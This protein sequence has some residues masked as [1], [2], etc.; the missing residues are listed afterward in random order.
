MVRKKVLPLQMKSEII[1]S[2][3]SSVG[4]NTAFGYSQ[5]KTEKNETAYRIYLDNSNLIRIQNGCDYHLCSDAVVVCSSHT[6][7]TETSVL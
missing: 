7:P 4:Q 1:T 5:Q 3:F 6:T 2:G